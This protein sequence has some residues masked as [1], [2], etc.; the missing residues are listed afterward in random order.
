MPSEW[1][2]YEAETIP[3]IESFAMVELS[4]VLGSDIS[5][6][7]PTRSGFLRFRYRGAAQAFIALR[8]CVAV[9]RI[10][11]FDIP[12]P[13]ALLGHEHFTR[14]TAILKRAAAAYA[15]APLTI[16]IGAAGSQSSTIRRLHLE[17]A[18][19]LKLQ[20]AADGKGELFMRLVRPAD[21]ACWEL[22]VRTTAQPLSKR[23]YREA[24]V[25]GALNA[26]VAFAM[27]QVGALPAKA[28]VVNMCSGS[29]TILIEHGLA[30]PGD[31]LVSIDNSSLMLGYA[32]RNA[33]AAGLSPTICHIA[34]DVRR[35]PLPSRSVDRIYADLPFGHHIGSHN[36]NLTLYPAALQ[37]AER[38][39]HM[40]TRF[41]LLTH[42]VKL[43]R[44]CLR[45]STWR[46]QD[47]TLIN[48]K[49]LHPRLFVLKQNSA[50]IGK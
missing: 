8:A 10:H 36:D 9:Y 22:L 28:C 49:G 25:P 39:A 6:I 19:A 35:L 2:S 32:R 3:G 50:T 20:P 11:R 47:E 5:Q 26:T 14:L 30:R 12:R 1:A 27:T 40:H 4:D 15:S 29:S 44:R 23:N 37:E 41:I 34:A 17:L 31:H 7:S 18:R 38:I 48:L 45:N 13:K 24:D 46:I 43:L 16:G 33:S 42:E 21:R